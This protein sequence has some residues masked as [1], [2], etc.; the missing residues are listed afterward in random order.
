MKLAIKILLIA[1]VVGAIAWLAATQFSS[2]DDD[3]PPE[4][5][6]ITRF[7]KHIQQRV[8]DELEDR[9]Y[10]EATKA[11]ASILDEISTEAA[12][13]IEHDGEEEPS[14]SYEEEENCRREA[15]YA[16]APIFTD[17]AEAYFQRAVWDE[18]YISQLRTKARDLQHTGIAEERSSVARQLA[19][20]ISTVDD[21]YAAWQVVN[22]AKSC[23]PLSSVKTVSS[24]ARD[25]QREPLTNC[26]RLRTALQQVP[27]DAK[28][29]YTT[30]LRNRCNDVVNRFNDIRF[31]GISEVRSAVNACISDIT[32][33]YSEYGSGAFNLELSSLNSIKQELNNPD[34]WVHRVYY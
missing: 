24:S 31:N 11:Y 28:N 5:P 15:F 29:A 1:A 20:T 14:I 32:E 19:T 26:E 33:Y 6:E 27:T 16:Y 10:D 17:H 21:Y 9:D 30:V 34:S 18:G 25:Y 23:S 8:E 3:T 2:A 4:T 7:E 12:I 22:Q 13:T